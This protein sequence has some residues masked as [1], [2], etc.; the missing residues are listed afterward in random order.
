MNL[1][2]EVTNGVRGHKFGRQGHNFVGKVMGGT[3]GPQ[4]RTIVFKAEKAP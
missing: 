1:V 4:A 2:G 3:P